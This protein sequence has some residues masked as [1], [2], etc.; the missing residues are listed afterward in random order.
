MDYDYPIFI[1]NYGNLTNKIMKEY[2]LTYYS[3]NI[4]F[5][6]PYHCK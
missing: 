2:L 4:S 3:I 6:L 1:P 5:Y